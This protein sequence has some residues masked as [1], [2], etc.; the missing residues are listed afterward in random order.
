MH[1][2]NVAFPSHTATLQVSNAGCPIVLHTMHGHSQVMQQPIRDM[3]GM[4]AGS[5]MF[6][7]RRPVLCGDCTVLC[8]DCTVVN[9]GLQV[10]DDDRPK[11]D[12]ELQV[13]TATLQHC[14]PTDPMSVARVQVANR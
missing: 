10:V 12:A 13:P 2:V 7:H 1:G 3:Q 9:G 5:T 8:G 14:I 4:C 6:F 11:T